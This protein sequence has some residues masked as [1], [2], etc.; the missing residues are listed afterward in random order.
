MDFTHLNARTIPH[1]VQLLDHLKVEHNLVGKQLQ[2]LNPLRDDTNFGSASINVDSGLF[3]DFA[4]DDCGG[5]LITF[6]AYIQQVVPSA[7]AQYLET[8]LDSIKAAPSQ[9][10]PIDAPK[11]GT[12]GA[13][14]KVPG[15]TLIT[16][17]PLDAP[18]LSELYGG[19]GAPEHDYV[20]HN[21][22]GQPVCHILRFK[23]ENGSKRFMP[24]TLHRNA[25]GKLLWKSVGLPTPRP[26]YNLHLLAQ[27]KDAPVLIVEG[28]KAADAAVQLF[29]DYVVTTSMNG[30]QS[31]AQSDLTPLHG[32]DVLIWPDNDDAGQKY[33]D[34]IADALRQIKPAGNIQIL[35]TF[36]QKPDFSVADK[37]SKLRKNRPTCA[38][39]S[40]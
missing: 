25:D 31:P 8:F 20:Y 3:K 18:P 22:L 15:L 2:F 11:L 17:I 35:D 26:L 37:D 5:D 40:S 4:V 12:T 23:K 6:V 1:I 7:A 39:S 14:K 24:Q 28:E 19:L 30:A 29:P 32:R 16:P 13:P 9:S 27:R 38:L 33:A 34:K 36:H 21:E 10:V